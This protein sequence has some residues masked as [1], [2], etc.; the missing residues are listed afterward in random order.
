M[1]FIVRCIIGAIIFLIVADKKRLRE[2]LPVSFFASYLAVISNH[3]MV[4]YKLWE[5]HHAHP[6]TA[7]F[8]NDIICYIIIPYFFIQFLPQQKTTKKML[9]YWLAWTTFAIS[10]EFIHIYLGFMTH[11]KW[12][13]F[14]HSYIADWILFYIFYKYYMVFNFQKLR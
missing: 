12:W 13:T 11:H 5:Y 10:L 6:L 14:A 9:L 7:S 8:A 1:F 3:I 2:I 4:Y